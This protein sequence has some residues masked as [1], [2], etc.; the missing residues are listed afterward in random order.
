MISSKAFVSASSGLKCTISALLRVALTCL[1]WSQ[2]I[3]PTLI[4]LVLSKIA[5]SLLI[6]Y[7]RSPR[8][9]NLTSFLGPIWGTFR[10]AV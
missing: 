10:F 5:T 9:S 4:E 1:P 7:H 8:A 2:M 6:L 3:A